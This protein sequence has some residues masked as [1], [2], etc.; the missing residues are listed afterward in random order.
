MIYGAVESVD[1]IPTEV[2]PRHGPRRFTKVL[3]LFAAVVV[4]FFVYESRD[5][6]SETY[7]TAQDP[8]TSKF[9]ES[10]R[11]TSTISVPVGVDYEKDIRS[12]S[13]LTDIVFS[14]RYSDKIGPYFIGYEFMMEYHALVAAHQVTKIGVIFDE[15]PCT[16]CTFLWS[17][18]RSAVATSTNSTLMHVFTELKKYSVGVVVSNGDSMEVEVVCRYVKHELRTLFPDD[19][20][21]FYRAMKVVY[22]VPQSEGEVLYGNGYKDV[23]YFI[24]YHT[25][26]AGTRECDHLHDG[27]GF[28]TGHN[29]ITNEFDINIQRVDPRATI[30]YW[31]YTIDMHDVKVKNGAF[32]TFYESLVFSD[33]WFGP[34]GSTDKKYQV[35]SG[36]AQNISLDP[37]FWNINASSARVTNAYGL[38]RSPWNVAPM[39]GLIRANVTY[40]YYTQYRSAPRCAEFYMAMN[41]SDVTTFMKYAQAN[42]HGAIHTIIGGVSN[43]DWKKFFLDLNFTFGESVGLQGFGFTKRAWRS[44]IMDCP[45]GCSAD[46]P[47]SEC[48]CHC[49][50]LDSWNETDAN[51]ILNNIA[52]AFDKSIWYVEGRYIGLEFL[53]LICGRY[54]E[55]AAPFLGDAMNSGATADPSFYPTHPNVDRLFQHRRLFGMTGEDTW[56]YSNGSKPWFYWGGGNSTFCWGHQPQSTMIWRRIFVDDQESDHYY[57]NTEMWEKMDPDKNFNR[58][59]YDNFKWDHCAKE[60]YPP[61]LVFDGTIVDD[62]GSAWGR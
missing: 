17:I 52:G 33:S 43:S 62:D 31:D 24:E 3:V 21:A 41:F 14:D 30:P 4:L 16:S 25:F 47:V 56:P 15:R 44:G 55:Y 48:V 36:L 13:S 5:K 9:A 50:K 12:V 60:N 1:V 26:L 11:S 57:T 35:L 61:D 22:T 28:L 37:S 6:A 29:A 42:A 39:T 45:S 23:G 34:M 54:P 49:P 20:D 7:R 46:T 18:D 38:L 10:G 19:A 2:S 27:M 59:V 51:A 53:K 8:A 58:Y 32:D 40:G